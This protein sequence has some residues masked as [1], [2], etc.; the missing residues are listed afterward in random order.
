MNRMITPSKMRATVTAFGNGRR[1][2]MS[3]KICN[4][5]YCQLFEI[6]NRKLAELEGRVKALE[7][8]AHRADCAF[9][10]SGPPNLCTCGYFKAQWG[11]AE[12]EAV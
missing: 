12:K 10:E 5:A 1:L 2:K 8:T 4:C 9:I 11:E 6:Q 3:D 7:A